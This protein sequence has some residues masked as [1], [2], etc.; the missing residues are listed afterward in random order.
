MMFGY[1]LP[2]NG[3]DVMDLLNIGPCK[4]IKTILDG[5]MFKAYENPKISKGECMKL[6]REYGER[7][8]KN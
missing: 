7:I 3:D 5:L 2:V 4:E 6:I 8:F 1:K